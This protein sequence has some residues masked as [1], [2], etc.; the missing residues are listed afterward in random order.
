MKKPRFRRRARMSVEL[1]ITAFMNLI[2]ILVPFLLTTA[3]FTRVAVLQLNLP[4]GSNPVDQLKSDLTLEITIRKD[5]LE[6]GDR[7]KGLIQRI[8]NT[9]K[10]Y[11]YTALSRLLQEIK[12]RFPDKVEAT[13]LSEADTAYDTLVQVMDT[14]RI[15]KAATD[16]ATVYELF[17]EISVGDAPRLSAITP[18]TPGTPGTPA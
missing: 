7:G 8:P 15:A 2:V 17:P 4:A 3:V 9:D 6:V 13:I 10:G 16:K 1:D 14:V 5:A 12:I 11:D 18:I